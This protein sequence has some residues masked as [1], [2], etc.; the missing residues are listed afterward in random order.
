MNNNKNI[1]DI[2][3]KF[4]S[5]LVLAFGILLVAYIFLGPS[6]GLIDAE[7]ASFGILL[8]APVIVVGVV[9]TI[10]A[11]TRHTKTGLIIII[12]T[13]LVIGFNVW[14][15]NRIDTAGRQHMIDLQSQRH[16]QLPPTPQVPSTSTH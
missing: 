14:N 8:A 13:V 2:V 7:S 10:L 4:C 1:F 5:V 11:F 6:L 3:V 15:Q 9:S 12:L 16:Q